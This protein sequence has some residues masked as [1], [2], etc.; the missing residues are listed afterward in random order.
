MTSREDFECYQHKEMINVWV[1]KYI[2]Y[3]NMIIMYCMCKLKY[4]IY[5]KCLDYVLIK[6]FKY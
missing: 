6:N 5:N 1:G 3:P 2:N 4:T